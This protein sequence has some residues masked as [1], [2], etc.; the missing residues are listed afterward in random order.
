MRQAGHTKPAL[1]CLD[2]EASGSQL[3][4]GFPQWRGPDTILLRKV[5][6][7]QLGVRFDAAAQDFIANQD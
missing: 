5:L 2:H 1:S 6:N 3:S 7:L 4:Q